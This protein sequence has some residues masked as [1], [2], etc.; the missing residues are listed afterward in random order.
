MVTPP[1]HAAPAL[2]IDVAGL[3]REPPKPELDFKITKRYS[4]AHFDDYL[5]RTFPVERATEQAV[6]SM[7]RT[8][9]IA[10]EEDFFEDDVLTRPG[11]AVLLGRSNGVTV[12]LTTRFYSDIRYPDRR[13]IADGWGSAEIGAQS[14]RVFDKN[15]ESHTF[16]LV[17]RRT[18]EELAVQRG[19]AVYQTFDDHDL[20]LVYFPKDA[21]VVSEL[22]TLGVDNPAQ[23]VRR[24]LAARSNVYGFEMVLITKQSLGEL[25]KAIKVESVGQTLVAVG[26]SVVLGPLFGAVAGGTT[27]LTDT[28]ARHASKKV[29]ALAV[30]ATER[31]EPVVARGS[32][33][34]E[35]SRSPRTCKG[36]TLRVTPDGW[37]RFVGSD[38]TW[39]KR[40]LLGVATQGLDEASLE[41]LNEYLADLAE[42]TD[43][44]VADFQQKGGRSASLLLLPEA[45]VV[46]NHELLRHGFGQL[47][48]SGGATD[49]FPELADAARD[50]QEDELGYTHRW[51]T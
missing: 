32:T 36:C 11:T 42:T 10:T 49:I 51:R 40:R 21:P 6:A 25:R 23:H 34:L 45:R 16:R 9:L 29:A 33:R 12:G 27:K 35:P 43:I 31:P 22:P 5:A 18:G 13:L 41:A 46:V 14:I 1:A 48:Q 2:A 39:K 15:S 3:D 44:Y 24:L 7:V 47:E 26:A 8:R 19:R 38:Y 28:L 17:K 30:A 4:T 50:A 37:L 20:A